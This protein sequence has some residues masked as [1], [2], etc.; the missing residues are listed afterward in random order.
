MLKSGKLI[1]VS[2]SAGSGKSIVLRELFNLAEYKYSVSATTRKPR[3]GEADGI[4]YYFLT[5]EDF[6]GKIAN[7]DML[8]YIEYSGNFYGTP[9]E[10]VEKMIREGYSVILEIEVTGALK[11]K[12]Q[13][14]EAVLIFLSPPTYAELERRLRERSAETEESIKK[15]LEISKEELENINKYGYFIINETDG[16]KRAA[17]EIHCIAEVEKYKNVSRKELSRERELMLKTAEE[18]RVDVKKLEK[19]LKNYYG[20]VYT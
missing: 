1:I 10:P 15:Q 3:T 6:S 7:G 2:G 17:F 18:C 20:G 19:F 14:P 11:V 9:R 5:R 16:Q 8:E 12:E 4:D 13:F